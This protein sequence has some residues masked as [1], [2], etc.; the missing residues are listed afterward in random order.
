M[1]R[2]IMKTRKQKL[3]FRKKILAISVLL[4]IGSAYAEDDDVT[5]LT[6][7]ESS[8]SVGAGGVSGDSKSKSIFTQYNGLR[9]NDANL[10]LD[11]DVTRLNDATGL[12]TKIEGRNLGLDD[13]DLNFSQTK[14]GD[15]KYFLEYNEI[16]HH[17]IRTI[18]T[19]M[20]G[21]GSTAPII[22]SLTAPG[23]GADLNL[24]LRREAATVGGEKWISPNLLFEVSFKDE[25]KK[26]ARLSGVGITCG[27]TRYPCGNGVNA[28]GAALLLPE[29]VDYNTKQID[30]KLNYS[31]DK[32]LLSGGYYGSYFTNSNG[33]MTPALSGGLYAPNGTTALAPTAN[34]TNYLTAPIALSPNN[35][36]QQFYVSGNY[37]FTPTTHSNFKYAYTHATQNDSFGSMGLSG[38]PAGIGDLGGVMNTNLLQFGLT[39]RPTAK[40]NVVAN[41][42]YEDKNDSTPQSAYNVLS[43]SSPLQQYSNGYSNSSTK[44]NGKLEAAYQLPNH[45]RAT[46]GI[47]YATVQRAAPP[48]LTSPAATDMGLAVGGLRENT[49]E[50]SYR[51]ELRKVLSDTLNGAV[52]VVHSQRTGD[53]WTLYNA[54]GTLPSSML[55]RNRNKVKLSAEWV[56]ISKLSL[57]FNFEDGKDTYTG[58]AQVG[59][60][61]T[62][63]YLAA[64]D[65]TYVLSENWK[66]TGYLNQSDQTQD[67]SHFSI[68]SQLED[69]NTSVSLG[70]VGKQSSRLDVGGNLS[71][72]NDSN[73]YNVSS[74]GLPDVTYRVTTLKLFGKYALQ[75]NGD[76]RVDFVHQNASFNEWTWGN[77]G[78]PFT[79]SDNTTVTMQPNQNVN[80]LGASYIYKFR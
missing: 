15:W 46:V 36:A 58:P 37:A 20:Q 34:L 13:R 64:I 69:V 75:N 76:V 68:Q 7:N 66:L 74:A 72:M 3:V 80:Y 60:S 8:V 1:G 35:Q 45:Y 62:K 30:A 53:S 17:D 65:A 51:A 23:L 43:G 11:I 77:N 63:M 9:N 39:S 5:K 54:T 71:Y 59:L 26:G 42:R 22:K 41:L 57:Q 38:G 28:S 49:R 19:G 40:L 4:A 56:P 12:W 73:R 32:F 70:V 61:D 44:I 48:S 47:D 79:Y 67:I 52:G 18:N 10:L 6:K 50:A 2:M 21:A 14:Q 78:T 55:D 33:S 29:P 27:F 16:T 25:D 31:G 24:Q